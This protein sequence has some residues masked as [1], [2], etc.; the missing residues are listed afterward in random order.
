M[1][2]VWYCRVHTPPVK[3]PM[4]HLTIFPF[5]LC[6]MTIGFLFTKSGNPIVFPFQYVQV[7][8]WESASS[9]NVKFRSFK[10]FYP[11]LQ[12]Y[13]SPPTQLFAAWAIRSFCQLDSKMM[14]LFTLRTDYLHMYERITCCS[15]RSAWHPGR[16]YCCPAR[17]RRYRVSVKGWRWLKTAMVKHTTDFMSLQKHKLD[18]SLL[19]CII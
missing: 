10:P 13:S 2:N 12:M 11:L 1:S 19:S 5:I 18:L 17:W 15:T 9:T 4:S 16:V 14:A 6:D 7:S 8:A 3:S